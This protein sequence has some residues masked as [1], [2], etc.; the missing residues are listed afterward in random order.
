MTGKVLAVDENKFCKPIMKLYQFADVL[1]Y[2][3]A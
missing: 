2:K 1:G 3:K